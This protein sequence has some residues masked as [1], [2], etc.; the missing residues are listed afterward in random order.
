MRTTS[1]LPIDELNI[2]VSKIRGYADKNGRIRRDIVDVDLLFEDIIDLFL[3]GVLGGIDTANEDTK[4][5]VKLTDDSVNEI[6]YRKVA[7]KTW[8]D[9][10]REYLSGGT[11]EEVVKVVE[12]DLHRIYNETQYKAAVES[13]VPLRKR[14][15]AI[16][17]ERTRIDHFLLD[18]ATV[19]IDEYFYVTDGSKALY[20]G[21]FGVAEQDCNCRCECVYVT[22]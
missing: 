10:I 9:R 11:A 17:D 14:W 5:D 4:A 16:L 1:L 15:S 18:G 2:L 22:A 7:G 12:T 8:V 21:G 3:L 20:P 13:G 19:D 6:V